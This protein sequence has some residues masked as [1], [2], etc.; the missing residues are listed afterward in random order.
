MV[1]SL[2]K[3]IKLINFC[4]FSKF[5]RKPQ[6]LENSHEK[7]LIEQYLFTELA[8]IYKTTK[9]KEP[10]WGRIQD[11]DAFKFSESCQTYKKMKKTL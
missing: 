8:K 1:K 5:T 11:G 10:F 6:N 3:S 9:N 2:Q 7:K 4:V